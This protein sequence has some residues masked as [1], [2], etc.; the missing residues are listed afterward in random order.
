MWTWEYLKYLKELRQEYTKAE[1]VADPKL[2]GS[3]E[4]FLQLCIEA[5]LD[6][7]NHII[8]DLKLG[9]VEQYSNVPVILKQNGFI[10]E[11]QKKLFLRMVGMR[12]ILVHEYLEI[13]LNIIYDIIQNHLDDLEGI[14]KAYAKRIL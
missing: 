8:A 5:L 3:S 9:K 12:N 10:T 4:R 11:E 6:I 7:G 13:D 1:F 2:Y 14:M